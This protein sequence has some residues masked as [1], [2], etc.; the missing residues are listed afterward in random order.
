MFLFTFVVSLFTIIN[1]L[2]PLLKYNIPNN[3]LHIL[4]LF[5]YFSLYSLNDVHSHLH[6]L[7]YFR[8]GC[9]CY[10]GVGVIWVTW[11]S[12]SFFFLISLETDFKRY[13]RLPVIKSIPQINGIKINQIN[14][15]KL[16]FVKSSYVIFS[17][18]CVSG[19]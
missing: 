4:Y 10:W 5:D 13:F 14:G 2:Y 15:R 3:I 6:I 8:H 16:I 7:I 18:T 1:F 12:R 17:C 11:V 19:P 9:L